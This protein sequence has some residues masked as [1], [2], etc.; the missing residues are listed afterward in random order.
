M[1]T[2]DDISHFVRGIRKM[3][4]ATT[5]VPRTSGF[6]FVSLKRDKETI[7]TVVVQMMSLGDDSHTALSIS[8]TCRA[9]S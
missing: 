5:E 6:E 3:N 1:D 2:V 8:N 4:P 9:R 7:L